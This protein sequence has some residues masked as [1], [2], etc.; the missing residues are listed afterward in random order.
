MNAEV[1]MDGLLGGR[2]VTPDEN[3]TLRDTGKY[4]SSKGWLRGTGRD[5]LDRGMDS[6]RLT[7]A[8]ICLYKVLVLLRGMNGPADCLFGKR[9]IQSIPGPSRFDRSLLTQSL[10]AVF[11]SQSRD[12]WSRGSWGFQKGG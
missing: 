8:Q 10:S 9:R 11:L 2:T 4:C 6:R 5:M 7:L 1:C 12:L 3:C